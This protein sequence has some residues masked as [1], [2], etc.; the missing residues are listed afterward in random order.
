M[1][2]STH[3]LCLVG[4]KADVFKCNHPILCEITPEGM[5]FYKDLIFTSLDLLA[6]ASDLGSEESI[7][8]RL[9]RGEKI[10]FLNNDT[11]NGRLPEKFT[12]SAEL[13]LSGEYPHYLVSFAKAIPVPDTKV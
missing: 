2:Q 6:T 11:K 13:V 5:D 12:I 1:E 9:V 4:E 8:S 3:R 10:L 7:N